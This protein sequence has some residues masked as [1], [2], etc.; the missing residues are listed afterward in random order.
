MKYLKLAKKIA[1]FAVIALAVAA[2][3]KIEQPKPMGDAGQ[4]LVK[5]IGAGP[6]ATPAIKA[7]PIDFVPVPTKILAVDVRRDIPN[8]AALNQAMTITIKDDNAIVAAAN[9]AYIV[10]PAAW[11]TYSGAAKAGGVYTI[12]LAPG[13]FARQIYVTVTD[14]TLM[15]PAKKYA[16][17]FT[18]TTAD[19]GGVISTQRSLVL[20]IGAKN[21]Y[22]GTYED[23]WTNFHPTS[24]PGYTGDKVDIELHTIGADECKMWFPAAGA[25]GNPAILGGG[26]S[27]FGA[28]EPAYKVNMAT[29][30]VTVR[31]SFSGATTNYTMNASYNSRYDAG[32]KTFDVKW[33]YSYTVPG[34][35]DAGCREW[36]QSLK[37]IGPR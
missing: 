37:Y 31:N 18:I 12:S 5:I 13:E 16:L 4:T 24:N 6:T 8:E 14:P 23:T 22:D 20:E 2:C 34:V 17:G 1:F 10:M 36:T 9:P 21:P 7:N 11:Y 28:Q 25:Y 35:F 33:G 15:D 29:N 26:L 30:A 3:K 27:Y 32:T 19:A